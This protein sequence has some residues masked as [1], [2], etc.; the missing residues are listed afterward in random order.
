MMPIPQM[1]ISGGRLLGREQWSNS[2]VGIFFV[3]P[4]PKSGDSH[5]NRR[6]QFKR[7]T[8]STAGRG[9]L[10]DRHQLYLKYWCMAHTTSRPCLVAP[11]L[12]L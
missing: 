4:W 11:G 2:R 8:P 6:L 5:M 10:L 3:P 7:L 1:D 12:T 9:H